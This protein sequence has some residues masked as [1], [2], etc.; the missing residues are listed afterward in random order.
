MKNREQIQEEALLSVLDRKRATLAISMGVG[1]TRIALKHYQKLKENLKE[2]IQALV[3]TPGP[4]DFISWKEEMKKAEFGYEGKVDFVTYKSL[5]KFNPSKYSVVYLD[6]VHN[7]KYKHDEFL[8]KFQGIILGLTGTPPKYAHGEKGTMISKYCPVA[9]RFSTDDGVNNLIIND[10]K[11]YVHYLELSDVPNITKKKK[12]GGSW[13]TSERKD[14][15]Y[16]LSRRMKAKTLHSNIMLMQ[17]MMNY[18]SKIAYTKKL[19]KEFDRRENRYII[20][21]NNTKQADML[22]EHSY[23]SKNTASE[24]NLDLFNNG[25]INKISCV[26]QLSQGKNIKNL[27]HGIIMHSY[28]NEKQSAQRIGR[29]LRLQTDKI[30]TCHIL[31]YEGTVDETWVKNALSNF[32]SNKIEYIRWRG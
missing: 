30:A 13:K 32:D 27:E 14:Y 2:D 16:L 17:S 29:L 24:Q 18:P 1:K 23:H 19:I 12:N 10:Y 6:E 7:I 20:F 3:V 22:C 4:S 8:S 21:A 5:N 9:Y 11:I 28:S 31:C 15:E 26:N 25:E